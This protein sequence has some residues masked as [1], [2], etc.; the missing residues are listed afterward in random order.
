MPPKVDEN[1]KE[2]V[3]D[4]SGDNLN[5]SKIGTH[6]PVNISA[7]KITKLPEFTTGEPEMWFDQ[8]DALFD[9]NG[10]TTDKSRFQHVFAYGSAAI[11]P[12]VHAVNKDVTPLGANET[13]YGRLRKR[14]IQGFAE[15]EEARLRNLFSSDSGFS[16]RPTQLLMHLKMR[17]GENFSEKAIKSIFLDK[18][19]GNVRSILVSLDG[20][21]LEKLAETAD[22]IVE[23][24]PNNSAVTINK[25]S[26]SHSV[27]ISNN[28][29]ESVSLHALQEQILKL[30]ATVEKLVSDRSRARS[31][32]RSRGGRHRSASR[33]NNIIA[34]NGVC[35]YHN[36]FGDQAYKCH[37][38]CI[39]KNDVP[40][41]HQNP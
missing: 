41:N 26:T 13:K 7:V 15:S 9:V 2:I 38:M 25:V 10:I 27:R 5:T 18:M 30:S 16:G 6:Q 20:Q 40:K 28:D 37:E 23:I 35:Y 24:S 1:G 12:Y 8:V 33:S 14:V 36:K 31:R 39:R 32:G 22:K 17:A 21:N 4:G 19:P 11:L 34:D 29:D 3:E